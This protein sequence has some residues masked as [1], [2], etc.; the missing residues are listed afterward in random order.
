MKVEKLIEILNKY[1]KDMDIKVLEKLRV[2]GAGNL[3]N[4]TDIIESVNQ[5]TNKSSLVIE[6]DYEG[7]IHRY[8]RE[9]EYQC[10]ENEKS[11]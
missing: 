9:E 3:S 7:Y 2:S 6:T 8:E 11:K 10:Q 5:D 1:P 4:I